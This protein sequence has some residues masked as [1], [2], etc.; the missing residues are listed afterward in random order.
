M[1]LGG[2]VRLCD[3]Q[4]YDC[5]KRQRDCPQS[6]MSGALRPFLKLLFTSPLLPSLSQQ[7]ARVSR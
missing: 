5:K 4:S 7:S 3:R 6:R 1:A 2:R